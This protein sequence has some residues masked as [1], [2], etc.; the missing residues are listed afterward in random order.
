MG[1]F[2]S[3]D[4]AETID[5]GN[6]NNVKYPDISGTAGGQGIHSSYGV[7]ATP[8]IKLVSP[9]RKIVE[10]DIWT[11]DKLIPTLEKY[12]FTTPIVVDDNIGK[13]HAINSQIEISSIIISIKNR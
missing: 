10:E 13:K 12:A 8:T 6:T 9:E 11:I 1:I 5:Y 3:A 4:D 2:R 7:N